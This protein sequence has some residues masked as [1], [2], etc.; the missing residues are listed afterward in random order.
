MSVNF[1]C[2]REVLIAVDKCLSENGSCDLYDVKSSVDHDELSIYFA[3]EALYD[4][5]FIDGVFEHSDLHEMHICIYSCIT[6]SGYAWLDSVRSES[7]W[8]KIKDYLKENAA[9]IA[10]G[11]IQ[12]AL[13]AVPLVRK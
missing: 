8:A 3:S 12:S 7:R 13:A 6:P 11:T 1:D 2:V 4:E 10:F 5:G 9:A